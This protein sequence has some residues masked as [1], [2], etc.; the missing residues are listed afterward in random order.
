MNTTSTTVRRAAATV[1][2]AGAALLAAGPA[3]AGPA[4]EDTIADT[5]AQQSKA[6]V[7]TEGSAAGSGVTGGLSPQVKAKLEAM[8]RATG[9]RPPAAQPPPSNIPDS[10]PSSVPLIVLALLGVSAVSGAA[11][12]TVYRYRHHGHVGAATA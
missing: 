9:D 3:F 10:D 1:V 2:L 11:G 4:P 5:S 12:Y 7:E 8:E 6:P